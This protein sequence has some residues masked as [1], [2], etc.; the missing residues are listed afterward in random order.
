MCLCVHA[1]VAQVPAVSNVT[2]SLISSCVIQQHQ[3]HKL[4]MHQPDAAAVHVQMPDVT[5]CNTISRQFVTQLMPLYADT[6]VVWVD[7]AAL[8]TSP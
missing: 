8:L 6:V 3:Q 1:Y 7:M 2:A 5:G 4:C